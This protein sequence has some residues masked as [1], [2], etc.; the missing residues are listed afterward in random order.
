ME[1]AGDGEWMLSVNAQGWLLPIEYKYVVVDSHTHELVAWE[2]GD[3]RLVSVD[4]I[5]GNTSEIPDGQVLVLQDMLGIT[6]QF[7]PRYLRLYGTIGEDIS[8]AIRQ[9]ISDVKSQ[10]FPNEREQY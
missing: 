2:E 1:Y 9:Y 10:D 5:D 4:Y 7:K 6:Q 3:N 8:N